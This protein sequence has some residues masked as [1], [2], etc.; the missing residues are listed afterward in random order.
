[1]PPGALVYI[2]ERDAKQVK[3]NLIDYDTLHV[4]EREL[5]AIEECFPFR[6][7]SSVTWINIDGLQDTTLIE[8]LGHHFQLHPLLLEDLM[9]TNHRPKME[10]FG[11]YIFVVMKM[12]YHSRQSGRVEVEHVSLVLGQNWVITFQ[13]H[14]E[15]TFG[16]IR[17]RI[18]MGGR[19]RK[20]GTDY[21][22]YALLD[23]VIDNY[24]AVLEEFGDQI[25]NTSTEITINPKSETLQTISDMKQEMILLRKSVWP[26]RETVGKMQR[27]ESPL[28]QDTT[29][30]YLRDVYDHTIQIIDTIESFR[31]MVSG[32]L[33]VYLSSLS[34]RMNAVMKVLTV[35]AAIFIPLT[36]VTGIYGMNFSYMPELDWH[37]G[38]LGSLIAMG[39]IAAVMLVYFKKK[40]WL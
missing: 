26:M 25:E 32:M 15:D 6:D 21:L 11:D 20:Q 8:S 5:T 2:G 36:F 30:I 16:H 33:D 1:M 17:E 23:G 22:A 28:I 31:D 34:N 14:E 40:R 7:T 10:D 24:F 18:R 37:Y 13:E 12:I 39:V 29:K 27:S 38:Y 3:I 4:D 9:N 19:I 35:F